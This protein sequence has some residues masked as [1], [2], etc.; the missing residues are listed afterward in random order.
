[1][2]RLVPGLA[3]AR[4]SSGVWLAFMPFSQGVVSLR[5]AGCQG[6]KGSKDLHYPG[7]APGNPCLTIAPL[8]CLDP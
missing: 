4:K 8:P 5:E 1:M 7:N 3:C 6:G 2:L